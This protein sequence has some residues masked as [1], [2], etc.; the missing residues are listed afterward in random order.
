MKN[1]EKKR[2]RLPLHSAN[3]FQA[4]EVKPWSLVAFETIISSFLFDTLSTD[5]F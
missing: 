4:F 3:C 5:R 2:A 1:K